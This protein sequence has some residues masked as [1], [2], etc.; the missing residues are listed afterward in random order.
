[1]LHRHLG[2]QLGACRGILHFHRQIANECG[3]R[4]D[5]ALAAALKF[6][7]AHDLLRDGAHLPRPRPHP[8]ALAGNLTHVVGQ[9]AHH[10]VEGVNNLT[11]HVCAAHAAL[12]GQVAFADAPRHLGNPA[13][14]AQQHHMRDH[15]IE[16]TD[17]HPR[18][19]AAG[20]EPPLHA[21]PVFDEEHGIEGKDH[22]H[23]HP[24]AEEGEPEAT[25]QT[26]FRP[27]GE[28]S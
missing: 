2:R 3:H 24:E 21:R 6:T 18:H 22:P 12:V 17:H 4:R 9:L 28:Y 19:Q 1:M 16:D 13:E 25:Q 20:D 7:M 27:H 5:L 23:R 10:A 26:G 14:L 11:N 8:V 15:I